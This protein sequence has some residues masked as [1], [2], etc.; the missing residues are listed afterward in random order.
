MRLRGRH[1]VVVVGDR[2]LG[3]RPLRLARLLFAHLPF[4]LF[5]SRMAIHAG[6][7]GAWYLSKRRLFFTDTSQRVSLP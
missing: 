6:A 1:Q 3:R 4:L 2:H 7:S 5:C